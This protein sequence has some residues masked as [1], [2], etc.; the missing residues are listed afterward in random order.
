MGKAS[1]NGPNVVFLFDGREAP[2]GDTNGLLRAADGSS[3]SK[4]T[5]RG[6][7]DGDLIGELSGEPISALVDLLRNDN[8][9]INIH[10]EANGSGEVRGQISFVD[11]IGF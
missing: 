9:Y 4:G 7:A 3:A 2:T 1:V 8:A 10:T 11:A 6:G 5:L